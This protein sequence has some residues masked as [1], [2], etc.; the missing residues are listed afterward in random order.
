MS[1]KRS[2][3]TPAPAARRKPRTPVSRRAFPAHPRSVPVAVP[4]IEDDLEPDQPFADG[5]LDAID[6]DLRHRMIS[7]AAYHLYGER[8]YE[9]GYDLDDWLQA[10]DA[11]DHLLLNPR[12]RA[13]TPGRD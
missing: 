7:E 9:D 8:G 4:D 11:I 13:R 10:E 12:G 5:A 6:P 1:T 2:P 3:A